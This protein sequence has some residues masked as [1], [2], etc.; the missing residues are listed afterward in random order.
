MILDQARQLVR[1][2]QLCSQVWSAVLVLISRVVIRYVLWSRPD[3]LLLRLRDLYALECGLARRIHVRVPRQ[4]G[5]LGL[6]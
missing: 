5:V 2:F 3:S 4:V 1:L 6:L